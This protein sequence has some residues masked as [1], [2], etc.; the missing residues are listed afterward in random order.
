MSY[1][2]IVNF[3]ATKMRQLISDKQI[4]SVELMEAHLNQINDVNPHVNAIV[5]LDV[6]LAMNQ[7]KKSD[8]LLSENLQVGILQ[9][10]PTA[11]KDLVPTKGMRTTFG[12]PLYK[13]YIPDFSSLI[14]ERMQSAGAITIGKTNTPEFGAG[15]QTYNEVFGET[16]NPYDLTKTCGG[17]SGGAA[18]SLASRMLPI[19]DGSDTGGSLRN[20]ANYCN[21]VGFRT[22]PGRVPVFPS[23]AGWSPTSVQGPMARNIEDCA[24]LLAAIS[25]PDNRVP[26]SITEPGDAFLKSLVRSFK[27]TKIAWSSDLGGLPV[28]SRTINVIES[29]KNVFSSLGCEIV[30]DCPDFS[31]ADESFRIWRGWGRELNQGELLKNHR[32]SLKETMVWDIEQG[33]NLTGPQVGLAEKKRMSLFQKMNSFMNKY[34]FFICPVSQVP[35]FDVKQRWIT[36]INGVQMN[37]FLEWMKSCYFITATAHPSISVPCGFTKDGLPVGIQ[38]VGRYRDE[39]GI[40]QFAK[41]FEDMT[42]VWKKIPDIAK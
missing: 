16:L 4:S 36:E 12:S 8:K 34:E 18:V 3:T 42:E 38:I 28:D 23:N 40:L 37:D 6:D 39:F 25:G 7:A 1:K 21:V 26:I 10:L 5:T 24:L 32:E 14:V 20:P 2:E 22:S 30:D 9:G 31:E 13:N 29:Q 35:P 15:S 41:A 17:S 19:A 33:V 27:G 11:H